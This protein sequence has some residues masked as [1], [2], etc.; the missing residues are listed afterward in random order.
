MKR[1][2]A[3]YILPSLIAISLLSAAVNVNAA[4]QLE[5][6][7]NIKRAILMNIESD[8][9]CDYN[10][11][12]SVDVFD[13]IRYKSDTLKGNVKFT[14]TTAVG[15]FVSDLY[16]QVLMIRPEEAEAEEIVTRLESKSTTVADIM[17]ELLSQPEYLSRNLT[18]ADYI[19]MMYGSL[20]GRAPDETGYS[21]WCN[22]I[23][24]MSR[25]NVLRGFV[26]ST[27]FFNRCESFGIERG[28]IT[29][30]ENRDVNNTLTLSVFNMYKNICGKAPSS[31]TLNSMTGDIL[32]NSISLE[33][34]AFRIAETQDFADVSASNSDYVAS[35]YNGLLQR[36]PSDD[37]L[38]SGVQSLDSGL[39]RASLLRK[40]AV[41]EEFI[42]FYR[43]KDLGN[44]TKRITSNTRI[45]ETW[46]HISPNGDMYA[47]ENNSLL[48]NLLNTTNNIIKENGSSVSQLYNYVRATTRYRYIEETKTLEQIESIGWYSFARYAMDNYFGVCYHLAA[49]MDILFEQA[50]YRCRIIHATHGSGDHY[51]NQVYIDNKWVNYDLTNNWYAYAWDRIINAGNYTFLG[52]V[53]PEYK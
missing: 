15:Y 42:D 28:S 6:I 5:K 20:L 1:K 3:G 53:R 25:Q 38:S 32:Y 33:V 31:D 9:S 7:T 51:W 52:Y 26:S 49:K 37:E 16:S 10:Q 36:G 45:G 44:Y 12:S 8:S 39:S 35:V 4:S 41:S 27:E 30:T 34:T 48:G 2:V 14:P 29:T 22:R 23:Q 43:N 19:T 50:G 21:N 46:Y 18:D 47:V 17:N 11:N 40:V 13:L 24:Y